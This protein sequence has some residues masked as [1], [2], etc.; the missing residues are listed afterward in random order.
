MP[1]APRKR[2]PAR[3]R[4]ALDRVH[5]TGSAQEKCEPTV[6]C[7]PARGRRRARSHALQRSRAINLPALVGRACAAFPAPLRTQVMPAL[8]GV[9]RKSLKQMVDLYVQT[10]TVNPIGVD[11][12]SQY[13]QAMFGWPMQPNPIPFSAEGVPI[14]IA[15]TLYDERTS[16]ENAQVYRSFFGSSVL[17]N[18]QGGGHCV[19]SENGAECFELMLNSLLLGTQVQDGHVCRMLAPLDFAWGRQLFLKSPMKQLLDTRSASVCT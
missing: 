12:A 10:A 1:T 14:V 18:A 2:V 16:I 19:G 8:D 6:P 11:M 9:G 13:M 15:N 3:C 7:Q 17:I 5:V 4:M